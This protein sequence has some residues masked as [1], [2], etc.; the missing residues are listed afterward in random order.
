MR[1]G[2]RRELVESRELGEAD[3]AEVRLVHAQ[4]DSG[5]GP[6]RPL[7]VGR[8]R[9]VGGPHLDEARAR[10]REHVRDSK[11]VADLDQLSARDDHLPP[12]GEGGEREEDGRR[13]VVDHERGLGAREP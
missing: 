9:P 2:D 6:D 12:L 11:A 3:D 13:V 10:A 8:P 1:A 7:V 4:E 5:L